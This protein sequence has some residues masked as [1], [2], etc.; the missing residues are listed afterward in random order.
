MV[1][2][3]KID[4]LHGLI[5]ASIAPLLTGRCVL[6]ELPY[7]TNVGDTLIWQG[8]IDF[9]RKQGQQILAQTMDLTWDDRPLDEDV[10]VLVQGG[11]NFG[12]VWRYHMMPRRQILENYPKNRIVFLPQSVHYDN[13]ELMLADAAAFAMHPDVTLCARDEESLAIFREYF[14]THTSLLVPDMAFAIERLPHFGAPTRGTLLI[15]RDD[16][17]MVP[18]E[19]G[20]RPE[21]A[22]IADWITF[23]KVPFAVWVVHMF[24]GMAGKRNLPGWKLWGRVGDWWAYHVVRPVIIRRGVWQLARYETIYSTRLHAVILAIL[25]GRNVVPLDNSYGKISRFMNTWFK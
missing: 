15:E 16:R 3:E 2:K 14:P 6:F 19:S 23:R 12:D 20:D 5:E 21:G 9:L 17:E 13:R 10:V 18:L 25:M 4:E 8:T 7:H 11:G 24:M 22:D 1:G